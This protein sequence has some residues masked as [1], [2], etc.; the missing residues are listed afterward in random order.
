MFQEQWSLC[1]LMLGCVAQYFFLLAPFSETH[2]TIMVAGLFMC[3]TLSLLS[4]LKSW[5]VFW[6]YFQKRWNLDSYMNIKQIFKRKK[7][8]PPQSCFSPH[9]MVLVNA[10]GHQKEKNPCGLSMEFTVW[11]ATASAKKRPM[12]SKLDIKVRYLKQYYGLNN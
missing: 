3:R 6:Q 5:Q 7:K 11:L 9:W 2:F 4:V 8:N 1:F 10:T 12:L